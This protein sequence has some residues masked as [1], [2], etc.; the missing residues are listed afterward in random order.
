MKLS[1]LAPLLG[2]VLALCP[3]ACGDGLRLDVV[4]DEC[5]DDPT[6]AEPGVCGCGVAETLCA[7]LARSLIHRY[8][9][10]GV[11]TLAVDSVGTADGLIVN[12]E[13]AGT[14]Q[15]D[16]GGATGE[17][18]VD[19]PNGMIS[20]LDSA[21]FEA[22]V[23]WHALKPAHWERIF[24]F[25]V[26]T[27]GEDQRSDGYSYLFLAPEL[28]RTAFRNAATIPA[29]AATSGEVRVDAEDP[30]PVGE[31]S[32]VAVVVDPAATELRLYLNAEFQGGTALTE[33]L[34]SINDVNNWLARSQF[35]ADTQFA[36]S[37]VEFRIYDTAL[38]QSELQ[39]SLLLGPSPYFVEH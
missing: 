29:H 17:Q 39:S 2:S 13:L 27:L 20:V 15:L 7:S 6:K 9:F 8:G 35:V 34:S 37:L 1:R 3:A 24:D 31:L 14:G 38:T 10:D 12:A 30:F 33:P 32:H 36:G 18:Y 28:F 25:G 16:L 4:R 21:T 19:L 26:S 23:I 11:G 5:M 22:W